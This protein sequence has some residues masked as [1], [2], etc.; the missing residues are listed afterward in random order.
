MSSQ[1][2][3]VSRDTA[4]PAIDPRAPRRVRHELRRRALTIKQVER[5]AAHMIR[6]TFTGELDGFTSLGFDDHVKLFFPDGTIS[7]E[8]APS[9]LPVPPSAMAHHPIGMG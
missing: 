5:I 9:V 1:A 2:P 8:G 6:V 7:D 4:P 3:A